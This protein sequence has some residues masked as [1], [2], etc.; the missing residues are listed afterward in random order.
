MCS[1]AATS[2]GAHDA[3]VRGVVFALLFS[4]CGVP[5]PRV[6]LANGSTC[7]AIDDG[8]AGAAVDAQGVQGGSSGGGG[9]VHRVEP[10]I[11]K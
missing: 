7:S 10:L 3:D 2:S 6:K 1:S 5:Q 4:L 9:V 11:S 8:A